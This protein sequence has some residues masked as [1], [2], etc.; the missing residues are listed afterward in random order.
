MTGLSKNLINILN[1]IEQKTGFDARMYRRSTLKRR[2][3][4]RIRMTQTKNYKEYLDYLNK[5]P[6]EYDRFLD[7]FTINVTE[8]FRD[9]RVFST[10]K[11]K[12]LP[13]LLNRKSVKGQKNI[14][15]WS[16][17]CSKGQEP[18]SL[19]LLFKDILKTRWK[20]FKVII[21]ATDVNDSVLNKAKTGSYDKEE[22]RNIPRHY[23]SQ[24]FDKNGEQYRIKNEIRKMVKFKKHDIIKHNS[25]GKFDLIFCRNLFIFF[26]TELQDK[27]L[28]KIHASLKKEGI[29][30]LGKAEKV[31]NNN[32]FQCLSIKDHI[33]KKVT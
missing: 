1:E 7:S 15:I 4:Y 33:Y 13:E 2:V 8:F 29:L 16:I 27:I 6:S 24:Y 12:I 18:Y 23:L 22:T 21:H 3:A 10:L 17:G 28:Q 32:S 20:D 30:V 9:R 19:A 14:R 5:N 26:E 25:L 11:R 31:N